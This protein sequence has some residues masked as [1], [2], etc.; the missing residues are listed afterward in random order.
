MSYNS[1][2]PLGFTFKLIFIPVK[3]TLTIINNYDAEIVDLELT[4]NTVV[5]NVCN[6]DVM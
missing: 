4:P 1:Y 3:F 6:N 2:K 5:E